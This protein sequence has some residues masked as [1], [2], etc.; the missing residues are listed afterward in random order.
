M[1]AD[2]NQSPA[3]SK[4]PANSP[5]DEA[6]PEDKP[7]EK[8]V[9]NFAGVQQKPAET[10]PFKMPDELPPTTPPPAAAPAPVTPA[11]APATNPNFNYGFD[12]TPS[13]VATT[14]PVQQTPAAPAVAAPKSIDSIMPA[15]KPVTNTQP[16]P[17]PI[18]P[19]APAVPIQPAT[20][21]VE[22]IQPKVTPVASPAAAPA[23]S[24]APKKSGLSA[25][26]AKLKKVTPA[27]SAPV[28]V[29]AAGPRS[30]KYL[31]FVIPLVLVGIFAFFTYLTEI[32]LVSFGLEKVYGFVG[33]EKM[34]GGLPTDAETALAKSFVAMKENSDFK[35]DG[36]VYLN[37]DKTIKNEVT[38]PL[39]GGVNT[40][41]T[42]SDTVYTDISTTKAVNA[43]V[44]G[45]LSQNGNDLQ[46]KITKPIGTETVAVK[47]SGSS[48]WVRSDDIKFND[49]AENGKW[50]SYNLTPLQSE[51]FSAKIFSIDSAKGFSTEGTRD[52]NEKL[53]D[54]RCYKYSLKNMQIGDTLSSIGITAEKIQNISGNVWIGVKDKLIRK[55]DLKITMALSQPLM[56]VNLSLNLSNYGNTGS[57]AAPTSSEITDLTTAAAAPAAEVP[58]AVV[59]PA[60]TP[61]T[62]AP[63]QTDDQTRKADLAKIKTALEAYKAATGSYPIAK[64]E[65]K[66]ST[67]GNAVAK[68]IV[69]T[70]IAAIPSDP[71]S[72]WSYNYKSTAGKTYTLIAHLDSTTDP[73]ATKIGGSYLYIL[74]N[75]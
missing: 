14:P 33:L 49:K 68:K 31:F 47:N 38:T 62:T 30:K 5:W 61:V 27:S 11:P 16:T 32:G 43:L 20:L 56:L 60:E 28:P 75:Q 51:S 39:A 12:A 64:T 4:P 18:A 65:I 7:V 37:I 10:Q 55:I 23:V 72:S 2:Q 29:V 41:T 74:K 17:Q 59:T 48:L 35:V 19:A 50:L 15:A 34:W 22:S 71:K 73:E 9:A 54:T 40:A 42:A 1:V 57:F 25:L 58:A 45:F 26:F 69:P 36:S 46:F 3:G 21:P 13:P 6:L 8:P 63:T 67:A 24:T 66:L 70:Y 44:T 52:A 53:G